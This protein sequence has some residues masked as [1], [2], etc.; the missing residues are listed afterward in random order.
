MC[1]GVSRLR[2]MKKLKITTIINNRWEGVHLVRTSWCY[3]YRISTHGKT[4][5]NEEYKTCLVKLMK[6][7]VLMCECGG[8]GLEVR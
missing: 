8:T 3:T 5:N 7:G 2:P 1:V 4:D 6:K